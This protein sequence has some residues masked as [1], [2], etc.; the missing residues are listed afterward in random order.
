MFIKNKSS[1]ESFPACKRLNETLEG[2]WWQIRRRNAENT[3]LLRVNEHT[4]PIAPSAF[5]SLSECKD[6]YLEQK[7]TGTLNRLSLR[8]QENLGRFGMSWLSIRRE[9]F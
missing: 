9:N 8:S 4:G 6:I 2:E 1:L 3:L 7:G 5:L